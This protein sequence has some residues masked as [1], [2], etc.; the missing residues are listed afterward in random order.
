MLCGKVVAMFQPSHPLDNHTFY[1]SV[2]TF[3]RWCWCL[4]LM[5]MSLHSATVLSAVSPPSLDWAEAFILFLYF[6]LCVRILESHK[7]LLPCVCISWWALCCVSK[8]RADGFKVA[9]DCS[10]CCFRYVLYLQVSFPSIFVLCSAIEWVFACDSS[11]WLYFSPCKMLPR[12]LVQIVT[13][14]IQMSLWMCSVCFPKCAF[15]LLT[16]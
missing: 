16:Q 14:G 4:C 9:S 15:E 5:S 7:K 1:Y 2:L 11:T 10:R 3:H 13:I 12:S 6:E 8:R